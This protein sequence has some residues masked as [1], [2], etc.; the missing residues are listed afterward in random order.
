M[1]KNT[2]LL[3]VEKYNELRDFKQKIEEGKTF[4]IY[5]GF[6]FFKKSFITTD[7]AILAIADANSLLQKENEDL[8]WKNRKATEEN[9]LLQKANEDLIQKNR[10]ATDKLRK[11]SYWEFRLWKRWSMY[12]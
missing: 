7:K 11:M 9:E 5:T 2:V 12:T 10:K 4:A 3:D 6:E 8:M 1:E